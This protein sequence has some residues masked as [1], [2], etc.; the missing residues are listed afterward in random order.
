MNARRVG[1]GDDAGPPRRRR[2]SRRA[3][4]GGVA[5]ED[6]AAKPAAKE[7][8]RFGE[9][10]LGAFLLVW[11]AGWSLALIELAKV[12]PG[13]Y[14]KGDWFS[15]GFGL[16]WLSFGGVFWLFGLVLLLAVLFGRK[17][18]PDKPSA[19]QRRKAARLAARAVARNPTRR[20]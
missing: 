6:K 15:L 18:D 2:S 12:A 1:F 3:E 17:R 9:I 7:M 14:A 19:F 16:V 11:L 10:V 8:S 5:P 20:D 4:T 13:A